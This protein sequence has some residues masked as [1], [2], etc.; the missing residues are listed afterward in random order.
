MALNCFVTGVINTQQMQ[1]WTNFI[2]GLRFKTFLKH[3]I[4]SLKMCRIFQSVANS[5]ILTQSLHASKLNTAF[6]FV[7]YAMSDWKKNLQY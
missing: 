5:I 7:Q 4:Q 6:I 3:K 2:L 1:W